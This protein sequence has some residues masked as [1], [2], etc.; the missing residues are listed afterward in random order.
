MHLPGW[1][2]DF[3]ISFPLISTGNP[4]L[5]LHVG[6]ALEQKEVLQEYIMSSNIDDAREGKMALSQICENFMDLI[7]SPDISSTD[8][9]GCDNMTMMIV[10]LKPKELYKKPEA[11][12]AASSG[13]GGRSSKDF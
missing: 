5:G 2:L 1:Y 8:G 9:M 7:I 6:L 3:R 12:T 11:S 13:D 10:D 4:E